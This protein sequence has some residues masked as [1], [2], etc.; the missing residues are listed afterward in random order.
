[1]PFAWWSWLFRYYDYAPIP[2]NYAFII[3]ALG[4]LVGM[5][6]Y[7]LWVGFTTRSSRKH[8]DVH[9]TAHFATVEE[10]RETGLIPTGDTSGRGVYCGAYDD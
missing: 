2:Y 1:Q 4:V 10:V 8:G 3:F 5:V 9:G 6:T 7:V